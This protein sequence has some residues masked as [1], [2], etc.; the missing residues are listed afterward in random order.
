[1]F[2]ALLKLFRAKPAPR[3]QDPAAA[4]KPVQAAARKPVAAPA[5]PVPP[6]PAAVPKTVLTAEQQELVAIARCLRA[7]TPDGDTLRVL[8]RSVD[9]KPSFVMTGGKIGDKSLPLDLSGVERLWTFWLGYCAACGVEGVDRETPLVSAVCVLLDA[10][11][12]GGEAVKPYPM[13]SLIVPPVLR[14]HSMQDLAAKRFAARGFQDVDAEDT[15][16]LWAHTVNNS[17]PFA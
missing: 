12:H 9:G 15:K 7:T 6:K 11:K 14:P 2:A 8:G 1:M 16:V 3:R 5:R 17:G 10:P 4:R 13:A